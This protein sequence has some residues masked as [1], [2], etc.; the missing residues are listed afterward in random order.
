MAQLRSRLCGEDSMTVASERRIEGTL[1]GWRKHIMSDIGLL[2]QELELLKSSREY[3][4][5]LIMD[6][7]EQFNKLNSVVSDL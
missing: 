3:E 7:G 5:R 2:R 6:R 1:E 4:T